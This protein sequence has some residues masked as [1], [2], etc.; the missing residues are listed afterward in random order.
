MFVGVSAVGTV[1]GMVEQSE[2]FVALEKT[3]E[4]YRIM[5]GDCY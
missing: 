3:P 1:G 4:G 5:A 2:G